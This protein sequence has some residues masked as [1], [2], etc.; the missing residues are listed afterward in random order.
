MTLTIKD[1]ARLAN[2]SPTAVS[3]ILNNKAAGNVS[4]KKQ[5]IVTDLIRQHGYKQNRTAKALIMQR[6]YRIAI[7]YRG[8]L[9]E[10][11][12]FGNAS[13]HLLI[14]SIASQLHKRDYGVDMIEAD[15]QPSL[16]ALS[17]R[18]LSHKADGF[19]FIN[20]AADIIEKISLLFAH[21]KI[22]VISAGTA[23][24]S[25][26]ADWIAVDREKSF[27][28]IVHFALDR[29][30]SRLGFL[31]T[32]MSKVYSMMKQRVFERVMKSRGEKNPA[33]GIIEVFDTKAITAKVRE[34]VVGYP[35]LEGIIMTDNGV[36]PLIQLV[37]ADRPLQLFG[38]GDDIFVSI[39]NPPIAYMKLPMRQ[40]AH[41]AVEHVL[42][43][44][45]KGLAGP[46]VQILVPCELVAQL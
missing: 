22:P 9:E 6:T 13:H 2:V 30:I 20:Y 1:I 4:P 24:P 34:Y 26:E 11:P 16:N 40:L 17:E 37:L 19:L 29:G 41:M 43:R 12:W 18:L 15:P 28:D 32:D 33:V 35:D 8:S 5:K 38:F 25:G 31:D 36:A 14:N 21:N 39:C 44:I 42:R 3:F 45:E 10:S 23:I 27:E 7:C 46:A